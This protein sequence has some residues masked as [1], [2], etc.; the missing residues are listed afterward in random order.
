MCPYQRKLEL[1]MIKS[2]KELY[3]ALDDLFFDISNVCKN[4][5][6]DDCAGYIWLLQQEVSVLMKA[7]VEILQVNDIS[8]FVNPF[9]GKE[10]I[11]IEQVKPKCPW[12][13]NRRCTVR[14]NRPLVCRMYPLNFATEGDNIY[15]VLHMDCDYSLNNQFNEEFHKRAIA[16]FG[17]I[18]DGFFAKILK[19]Y[20][21]VDGITKFPDGPN[22]YKKLI[23]VNRL[24]SN[25]EKGGE[26]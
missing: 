12:Y 16:L 21:L 23:K 10:N 18:T 14:S 9:Q 3:D 7:G 1:I 17:N 13:K 19:T 25:L 11:D 24:K 8:N 5:K 2:L 26:L 4:C 20:I 15:L 6:Y 22:N